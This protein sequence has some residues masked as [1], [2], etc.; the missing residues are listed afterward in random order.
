MSER[1]NASEFLEGR[2]GVPAL[3]EWAPRGEPDGRQYVPPPGK[4][5]QSRPSRGGC[6]LED[7]GVFCVPAQG[8][9]KS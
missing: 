4:N 1:P 5:W 2:A 3:R 9:E 7:T 6:Q 8:A